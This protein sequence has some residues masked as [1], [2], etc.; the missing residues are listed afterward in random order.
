MNSFMNILKIQLKSR[1]GEILGN[2]ERGY[3]YGAKMVLALK[4][5]FMHWN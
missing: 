2:F 5:N 4:E 3:A 1:T